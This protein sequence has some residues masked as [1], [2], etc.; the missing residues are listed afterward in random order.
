MAKG[1]KIKELL[2]S[3]DFD[4]VN[5]GLELLRSSSTDLE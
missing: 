5:T 3:E 4:A 1:N 2:K